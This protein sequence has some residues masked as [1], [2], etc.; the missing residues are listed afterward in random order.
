M[1]RIRKDLAENKII[2]F[3]KGDRN[4]PQCGFSAAV[5]EVLEELGVTYQT[6]NILEDAELR[7]A[8]KEFS[9]W[10]TYPQLYLN[11]KLIGGCD[12]VMEMHQNNELA[13]LLKDAV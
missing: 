8:L 5:V 12:I 1:E 6:R 11:G 10:P 2:L 9:N 4:F 13:P 7:T 3:M